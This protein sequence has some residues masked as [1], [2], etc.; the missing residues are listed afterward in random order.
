LFLGIK[1]TTLLFAKRNADKEFQNIDTE[2]KKYY[3]V[4]KELFSHFSGLSVEDEKLAEDTQ[5]LIAAASDFSIEKDGNERIIGYAN[6]ILENTKNFVDS[7]TAADAENMNVKQYKTYLQKFNREK[8]YYNKSAQYLR[9]Y[10]D[11]FPT[12]LMARLKL[13]KTMDYLN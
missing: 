6:S 2:L 1:Y 4:V 7:I 10:V 13:I 11:V 3:E 12:S 8:E 9:H 5:K